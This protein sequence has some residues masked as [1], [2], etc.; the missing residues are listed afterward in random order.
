MSKSKFYLLLLI[1]LSALPL[2]DFF[3]PGLPLTHDGQD[4][5]ARI[6]NFC[7]SLS[8]GNIIPRWAANLNWGYGHPILMF[9]YPLSNYLACAV[10]FLG[11]SLVDSTKFVFVFGYLFSGIFMFLWI[12]QFW[13]NLAG[14]IAG[15][16]YIFAPYRFV[17]LYV[18][19]AIGENLAF[20]WLPLVCFFC[21]KLSR[22]IKWYYI[23]GGVFSLAALI[24]SHNAL[25]LMF[26]PVIFGYVIWLIFHSQ[27]KMVLLL[28][29][30]QV[31][32]FGF[33]VSAFFWFPA[34]Y[35]G[36]Y[37]LRD[38]VT[39]NNITGFEKFSRLI[40]SPWS[41]GGT[42]SL[43]VQVGVIHWLAIV[44]SPV[45][46]INF[47]KKR[48]K[49]WQYLLFL[50]FC[51]WLSVFMILPFSGLLYLKFSLL[52]KFQFVWRFLSLAIIPPV[53]FFSAFF[54]LLAKR[55]KTI[56]FFLLLIA[57]LLLNKNYWRANGYLF[58]EETFYSEA[59][60]GT[61]DTGESAP[62]WSVRFMEK[63]PQEK[64]KLISGNGEVREI[65]RST[66]KHSFQVKSTT[67]LRLVDNTLYFPGW[68]VLIDNHPAII[69]FQDPAW[70]GLITFNV[71]KGDHNVVVAFK[72]TKVRLFSD[73][74]SLLGFIII[75]PISII[76]AKVSWF[77]PRY[78]DKIRIG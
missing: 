50:F 31:L 47:Y 7:R 29:F 55:T 66:T 36:R 11:F 46:I 43:S 62:R 27:R 51:F 13:G 67:P 53:I 33:L 9:L 10:R 78:N 76:L 58:K 24:L 63:Y 1:L 8:E 18:R 5:V 70:G 17:N 4:H 59:Y 25:S 64:I 69:E 16:L 14:L 20:T 45:V 75:W 71:A 3:R 42:G 37:T 12:S 56:I 65:N 35:E 28:I 49:I 2:F 68:Q 73:L 40:W 38:I 6:A 30:S 61:T 74:A 34:Y 77:F 60:P 22:G 57:I 54:F 41:F 52:Q 44:F 23:V 26:L 19:G 15:L 72:E 32:L 48:D 39:K 21:F